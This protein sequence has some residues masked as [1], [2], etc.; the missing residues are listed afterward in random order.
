M[1]R[2]RRATR[3]LRATRRAGRAALQWRQQLRGRRACERRVDHDRFGV[4]GKVDDAVHLGLDVAVER[5]GHRRREHAAAVRDIA[6][7]RAFDKPWQVHLGSTESAAASREVLKQRR[8]HRLKRL[9]GPNVGPC[10]RAVDVEQRRSLTS[11]RPQPQMAGPEPRRAPLRWFMRF[12]PPYFGR[13]AAPTL[14]R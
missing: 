13:S 14:T 9:D 3:S 11:R 4:D 8:Q 5:A 7:H 10:L 1:A 12:R 2:R 6:S